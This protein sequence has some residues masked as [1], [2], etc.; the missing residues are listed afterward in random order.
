MGKWLGFFAGRCANSEESK[1][2]CQT[3]HCLVIMMPF[4]SQKKLS[5]TRYSS[6]HLN[7]GDITVS[8][9]FTTAFVQFRKPTCWNQPLCVAASLG[10]V[11]KNTAANERCCSLTCK[12]N[13]YLWCHISSLCTILISWWVTTPGGNASKWTMNSTDTFKIKLKV[14]TALEK[15]FQI[16]HISLVRNLV[17]IFK[18]L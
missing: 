9:L 3:H 12:G 1:V 11:H 13:R 4:S 6:L 2:K 8:R 17:K 14:V 15:C 18:K 7:L 5:P 10:Y 16:Y